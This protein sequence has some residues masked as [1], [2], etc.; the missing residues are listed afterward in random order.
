[1]RLCAQ[2]GASCLS[3][4]SVANAASADDP[5]IGCQDENGTEALEKGGDVDL[6]DCARYDQEPAFVMTVLSEGHLLAMR[7]GLKLYEIDAFN[8]HSLS[9]KIRS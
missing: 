9:Q 5:V 6:R 8:F 2:T 3:T 7:C 1:M 4:N